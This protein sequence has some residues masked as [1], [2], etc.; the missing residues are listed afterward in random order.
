MTEQHWQPINTAPRDGTPF[1]TFSMDA[2]AAPRESVLGL[3]ATPVLVMSW[4]RT[5]AVPY[6]VDE[7]G[8]FHNFHCYEPTHWMPLPSPPEDDT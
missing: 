6:P 2:A 5:A 3:Q 4:L 7:H 1:L 8:Y